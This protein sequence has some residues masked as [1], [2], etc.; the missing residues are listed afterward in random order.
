MPVPFAPPWCTLG[1]IQRN[2]WHYPLVARWHLC[3]NI[4]KSY[5][6]SAWC[7]RSNFRKLAAARYGQYF[8]SCMCQWAT[9][10]SSGRAAEHFIH[11]PFLAT[12]LARWNLM[13]YLNLPLFLP[14]LWLSGS[15][16]VR[17]Q[18]PEALQCQPWSC[19]GPGL[20]DLGLSILGSRIWLW[21]PWA[22]GFGSEHPEFKDLVLS[23]L[24]SRS[25]FWASRAQ[26]FGSEHPVL[27]DLVLNILSSKIW[28]WAPCTQG[29]SPQLP[30]ST[31]LRLFRLQNLAPARKKT[32]IISF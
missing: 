28:F 7:C 25:L 18:C 20:R 3:P 5:C 16:M 10:A 6:K 19:A 8:V 24:Y 30:L 21:A 4:Q 15:G 31:V 12:A 1:A 11:L 14:L 26:E 13:Y 27:R 22:Q 23:I 9:A 17:A 32:A 2:Q 29:F